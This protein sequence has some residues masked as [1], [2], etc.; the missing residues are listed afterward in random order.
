MATDPIRRV[1]PTQQTQR[2]AGADKVAKAGAVDAP[3]RVEGTQGPIAAGAVSPSSFAIF[4]DRITAGLANQ[5]APDA[6][7]DDLVSFEAT[8]SFGAGASA[9]MKASVA[10]RFRTDPTLKA[11]IGKLFE[12]ATSTRSGEQA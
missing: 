2:A 1:T 4:R 9:A 8:R 12:A 6:I 11:M 10:E 3:F 5:M 7:I